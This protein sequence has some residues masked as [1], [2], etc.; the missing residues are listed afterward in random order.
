M[1]VR[2]ACHCYEAPSSL[3]MFGGY[4]AACNTRKLQKNANVLSQIAAGHLPTSIVGELQTYPAKMT[5]LESFS[6]ADVYENGPSAGAG[7]GDPL[8]REPERVAADVRFEMV[9]RD[10]AQSIYGVIV[11]DDAS[12]DEAATEKRRAEIRADR[13]GWKQEKALTIAPSRDSNGEVLARFGDRASIQR[14]GPDA[15]FRCDCGTCIAPAS[16]NWKPYARQS[17]SKPADL[18]PRIALHADIEAIRYACPSC[19]RLHW[20]EIK[21]KGEAPLFDFEIKA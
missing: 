20:V 21:L 6:K 3:G 11:R 2:F 7:W 17:P 13:L 10:V 12:V 15:W 16:E 18:G 4:P 9:S 1:G 19:A 8:E 14:I 5:Q